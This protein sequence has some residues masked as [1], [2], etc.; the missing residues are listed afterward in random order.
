MSDDI[1][2]PNQD[3]VLLIRSYRR[4]LESLVAP[5]ASSDDDDPSHTPPTRATLTPFCNLRRPLNAGACHHP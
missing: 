2:I 4:S 1:I 3:E 5:M